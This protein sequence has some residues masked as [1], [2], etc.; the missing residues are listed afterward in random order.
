MKG[1]FSSFFYSSFF[2]FGGY[3][4]FFYFSA[5]N[6]AQCS[7]D[8]CQLAGYWVNTSNGMGGTTSVFTCPSYCVINIPNVSCSISECQGASDEDAAPSVACFGTDGQA[9]AADGSTVKISDI[10]VGDKLHGND[11][12][13]Y[14]HEVEGEHNVLR[15][16]TS[17]GNSL[18]VTHHHLLSTQHKGMVAASSVQIGDSLVGAKGLVQVVSIDTEKARV[19]S[20]ITMSGTIIVDGVQASCYGAAGT[21]EVMHKILA[22]F[23]ALFTVSPTLVRVADN[24]GKP[25]FNALSAACSMLPFKVTMDAVLAA[26]AVVAISVPVMLPVAM[27]KRLSN[28]A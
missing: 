10:Q 12:V 24:T 8:A 7:N 18:V 15:I 1:F 4:N 19:R 5:A 22:P 6:N 16:G 25:V 27:Y 11:E 23:R 14:I 3:A 9:T 28:R 26:S 2:Y 21:H 13:W 20:P 17:N